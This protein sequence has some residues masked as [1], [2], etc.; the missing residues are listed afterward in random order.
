MSLGSNSVSLAS[1][2]LADGTIAGTGTIT[3]T[4]AT[5]ESGEIDANLIA[6]TATVSGGDYVALLGDNTIGTMTI[7][8]TSTVGAGAYG[9]GGGSVVFA[10]AGTL[11]A[12][13]NSTISSTIVTTSNTATI[14]TNGYTIALGG[15]ISG[16]NDVIV[17]GGGTANLSG[18]NNT[19]FT[20]NF[21]VQGGFVAAGSM[22][23]FGGASGLEFDGGGLQWTAQFNI[24]STASISIGGGGATFD[25]NSYSVAIS[26]TLSGPGGVTVMDTTPRGTAWSRFRP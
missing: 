10:G 8:D 17:T 26:A 2:T 19:G 13:D 15:G 21:V 18:G 20:G 5:L 22:T 4:T 3:A 12:L 24:P 9:L 7:S 1:L 14:D 6:T 25:S 11:Q 16:M 23:D